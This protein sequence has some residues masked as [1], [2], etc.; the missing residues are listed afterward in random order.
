M[1]GT[2]EY[3]SPEQAAGEAEITI[4]SDAYSLAVVAYEMLGGEPPIKGSSA[5]ATM[6]KQVTET[7]R[8]LRA[9][10]PDAPARIERILARALAKSPPDRFAS[11]AELI[12][13]LEA[14]DKDPAPAAWA[15]RSIAVLPF[16]NASPDPTTST[17]A[18]GSPTS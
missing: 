18:T 11:V 12:A 5:R 17:S 15:A 14:E 7:P 13:A 16:V 3:M 2:P 8:P 1:L 6:A 9:V 4:A 10:R